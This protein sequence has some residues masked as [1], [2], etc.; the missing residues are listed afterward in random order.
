ML[1]GVRVPLIPRL[2]ALAAIAFSIT[3]SR[4]NADDKFTSAQQTAIDD[5]EARTKELAEVN[6]SLWK[7][8]EI[9]LKEHK[10]AAL[11]VDKLESAGF[12][13][14]KGVSGMPT[15]F[16]AS[17]G[18]GK[19]VIGILAE[20]DALP[21]LSQKVSPTREPVTEG[22]AGHACGHSGLGSGALGAAL[23][24]KAAIDKQKLKGTIRLYGTPAEE[25]VIGKVYMALDKQFDDLDL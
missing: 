15:A 8:A 3:H 17:Y 22:G 13:V 9:G 7:L 21:G 6:Q 14:K 1:P 16:V 23:A 20:Y 10:S 24:V 4:A 18:A 5:V 2:L 19:P 12:S 25:T 11:L